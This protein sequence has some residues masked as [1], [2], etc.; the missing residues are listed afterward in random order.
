MIKPANRKEAGQKRPGVVA[1]DD[2]AASTTK[3][4]LRNLGINA[5]PFAKSACRAHRQRVSITDSFGASSAASALDL[6]ARRDPGGEVLSLPPD[7]S[8]LAE[9][10]CG[11][12]KENLSW[13]NP[14]GRF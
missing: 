10:T 12:V 8:C 4:H 6:L 3:L 13:A 9:P 5:K 11:R 14:V 7:E 2:P 1:F